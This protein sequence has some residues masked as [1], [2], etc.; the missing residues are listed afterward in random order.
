M[1]ELDEKE[2]MLDRQRRDLQA[3]LKEYK[4]ADGDVMRKLGKKHTEIQKEI[5]VIK[6]DVESLAENSTQ[7]SRKRSA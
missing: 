6:R 2:V 3:V 4:D 7:H 5:G 1:N